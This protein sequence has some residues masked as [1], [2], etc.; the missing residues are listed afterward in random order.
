MSVKPF[1]SS[2]LL[3][4][5]ML[6][7]TQIVSA[8]LIYPGETTEITFE[9]TVGE[10]APTWTTDNPTL[11]LYSVGFLCRVTPQAYFGGTAT[12]TC[13]YKDQIGNS[14]YTRTRRWDFTCADTQISISPTSKNIKID[15]SFQL[16][17][18]FNKTTYIT[19]SI[20]FTGYDSNI[21]TV[22]N[23]G[24]VTA[25]AE[26][27]TQIYVKSNIGTNSAICS[28]KVNTSS[29]GDTNGMTSAYDNWDS[30]NTKVIT[31][32][33]PGTLSNFISA[34]EKYNITNLT[35]VGPLNGYDLRLLRD[36]CG[37]DENRS[38]TNGKL[39]I[40]DL[41]DAV[42]VSGGPWYVKAWQNYYYIPDSQRMPSYAFAW[43]YN[44]KKIRFPKYCT[45]LDDGALL[46]CE[47]LE[48][49]SIPPGVTTL[50]EQSLHST[51]TDMPMS[52]L[53]LPSSMKRFYT[54]MYRCGNLTDVYCYAVEPPMVE[55][56]S[57]FERTNMSNGTLYVPKGSAQAYWRAEGWRVFKDIKETLDIFNT[58]SVYVGE[59]GQVNYNEVE[60]KQKYGVSYTGYQAFEVPL[61]E[62]LTVEIIPEEG[63]S[64]SKI[65][66]NGQSQN[67]ST[68]DKILTIGKLT[69]HTQL[70]VE[71]DKTNSIDEIFD[72]DE[73]SPMDVFNLQGIIIR[74]DVKREEISNLP[75]GMYIIKRGNKT[76][77]I[78]QQ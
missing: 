30:K 57:Y 3:L 62:E 46:Q 67:I 38:A 52:V 65:L 70:K 8:A 29:S 73:T 77:K 43:M 72:N 64:I 49:I 41:K 4:G 11:H 45:T 71:F 18:G 54:E 5:F 20:Q 48:L 58:F 7:G 31:L 1:L 74:K 15:E 19:P 2:F 55:Y 26:G 39:V 61:D 68:T 10:H 35:I 22:S 24:L 34:S 60:I 40:L 63:Y 75:S 23:S 78:L 33:Q 44:L 76:Y 53:T 59:H 42:F 69:T 37:Q 17:W 16:S 56:Q 66:I 14:T 13:T 51:L 25:K 21:I 47:S 50:D 12:V 9:P 32:E 28:V 36:M 27:S 6:L